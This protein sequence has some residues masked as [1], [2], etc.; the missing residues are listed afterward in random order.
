VEYRSLAADDVWLST[1]NGRDTVT[2]SVHEDVGE[3][4]RPYFKACE[5]IFLSHG[6][7]PHWGKVHYLDG[8]HLQAAHPH[9]EQWWAVRDAVDPAG[10]FLNDYLKSLR[11]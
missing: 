6:G 1:A 2:V 8:K 9:W 3:D 5:E 4:E 11:T 10:S 7:R